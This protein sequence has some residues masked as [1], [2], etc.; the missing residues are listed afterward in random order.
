MTLKLKLS[1]RFAFALSF[2]AV[3]LAACGNTPPAPDWQGNAFGAVKSFTN[4][5]LA[6]DSKVADFEFARARNEISATGRPELLARAELVRCAA[7]VASLELDGCAATQLNAPDLAAPERAYALFL[8]SGRGGALTTPTTPAHSALDASQIALLPEQHRAM[9]TSRDDNAR[10]ATLRAMAD[11]LARLVAAG[12]LF[13]QGQLPPAGVALAV[14]TASYQ[15]WRRPLL[16]WLGVQ[17][18][19]AQA[20]GDA[21]AQAR[22]QRRIDLALGG[23]TRQN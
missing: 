21:T 7:R 19:L 17:L 12:V 16:A 9:F 1:V 10:V 14:D 3:L 5:Y 6:G 11:P 15:G 23:A 13:G 18:K 4:A 2:S 22:I 8:D 20:A